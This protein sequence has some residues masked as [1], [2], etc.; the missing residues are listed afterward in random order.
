M[1]YIS[2][3]LI[4]TVMLFAS[5]D[6]V[7]KPTG[8]IQFRFDD[9]SKEYSPLGTIVNGTQKVEYS[10][11][12]I[13][14]S[15][16]FDATLEEY[17]VAAKLYGVARLHD[18]SDDPLKNENA[19]YDNDTDGFGYLGELNIQRS[20]DNHTFTIGRVAYDTPLVNKNFRVTNNA[21][22]GISYGY[23]DDSLDFQSL[24]FHKVASS[25]LANTVPFNHRYGF[26]GYGLGY[27][28]G[29]FTDLSGHIL[30]KD[31]STNGAIHFEL[32]Y[33]MEN[34]FITLENL[35]VDN[36]F[37]TT[38]L[39]LG[40]NY[41]NLHLKAGMIYQKSVGD[42]LVEKHIFT[43][44]QNKKLSS[45]HYH[46]EIKYQKEKFAIS[47]AVGY[48]PKDDNSIYQGTLF[49]PFSNK[50]SWI[51]GLNTSHATIAD[52]YSQKISIEKGTK[53]YKVP[54]ALSSGYVKYNIGDYNG[55]TPTSIDTRELY[56]HIKGYFSKNLSSKIQHSRIHNYDPLTKRSYNTKFAIEYNF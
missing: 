31:L 21:Y 6:L 24:Y 10:D 11:Y 7:V 1:R 18:K 53:L 33:K 17:L 26:L 42:D 8:K 45:R 32:N 30:N 38:N 3:F 16:G 20:I 12:T 23:K 51:R 40:Y 39:T 49:S 13:G 37:N 56:F 48:T 54:V 50:P 28:T 44:E 43:S 27:N 9:R 2:I 29:G 5:G 14:G 19:Y 55:L 15:F 52:T 47:Y 34:N 25:T 4:S 35:L 41:S 46:G 36:F 22:E